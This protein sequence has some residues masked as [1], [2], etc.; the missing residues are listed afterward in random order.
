MTRLDQEDEELLGEPDEKTVALHTADIRTVLNGVSISWLMQAFHMDRMTVKK[1][2]KG[3]AYKRMERNNQPVYDFV[4]AC[5]CLVKPV[6]DITA[7]IKSLNV[8]ELPP[9]LQREFWDARTKRQKYLENAGDLW[10]T[11]DV[12]E[13]FADIFKLLKTAMQLWVDSL[14]RQ[15]TLAPDQHA[16]LVLA[17]DGLQSDIHKR[18][19]DL[20][21]NGST[22]SQISE[23]EEEGMVEPDEDE[24]A[25]EPSV[26][27]IGKWKPGSPGRPPNWYR[28]RNRLPGA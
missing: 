10:R 28:N 26:E 7:F 8:R 15:V 13:A 27:M 2:L 17:V 5:Q 6:L 3:L 12:R 9:L 16:L 18:I 24:P 11:S 14:D 22:R 23:A 4:E 25:P 1:R 20:A 19:L 21:K